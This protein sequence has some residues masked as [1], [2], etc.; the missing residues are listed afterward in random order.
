MREVEKM[1][2]DTCNKEMEPGKQKMIITGVAINYYCAR[3]YGPADRK[4]NPDKY[5]QLDLM[6]KLDEILKAIKRL[7]DER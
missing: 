1:K 4:L 2:C 3:C 6:S 7:G 5:K